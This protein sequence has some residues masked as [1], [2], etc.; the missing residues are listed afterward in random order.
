MQIATHIDKS[1]SAPTVLMVSLL[2]S[3]IAVFG[4]FFLTRVTDYPPSKDFNLGTLM[5]GVLV[6]NGAVCI[7]SGVA[8]TVLAEGT[9]LN[10]VGYGILAVVA[11]I[12]FVFFANIIVIIIEALTVAGL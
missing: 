9:L 7:C 10:R 6:W 1:R 3:A 4:T 2:L 5:V 12:S 8:V 11:S